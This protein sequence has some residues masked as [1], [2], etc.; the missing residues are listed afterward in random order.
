MAYVFV[1][2]NNIM[3]KLGTHIHTQ[4]KVSS[5]EYCC[6]VSGLKAS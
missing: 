4:T 2:Y 1:W 3:F 5:H 6:R